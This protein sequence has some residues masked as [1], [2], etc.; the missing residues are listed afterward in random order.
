MALVVT[1]WLL[2][3]IS[4]TDHIKYVTQLFRPRENSCFE[5]IEVNLPQFEVN[6]IGSTKR[7][8]EGAINGV[9][10]DL[11]DRVGFTSRTKAMGETNLF[12]EMTLTAL[13]KA[14]TATYAEKEQHEEAGRSLMCISE[15]N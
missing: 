11:Y 9:V 12:P 4:H 7:T 10:Y 3:R 14:P 5:N 8:G 13:D 2:W 15:L 1:D 6:C